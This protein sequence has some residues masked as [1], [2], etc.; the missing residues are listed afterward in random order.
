VTGK[1]LLLFAASAAVAF[2]HCDNLD[3]PVVQAAQRALADNNVNLVLPWVQ[4]EHESAVRDAFARTHQ[5]RKL[6]SEAGQL[7]DQWFFETVVRVHRQG[8]GAPYEGLK[9]AGAGITPGIQAADEAVESGHLA[10]LEKRLTTAVQE[11]LRTKFRRLQE[12]KSHKSAGLKQ[13]R[14]FVAAYVEF[15][16]FAERVH[17]AVERSEHHT[18]EHEH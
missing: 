17:Q 3:G 11:N 14:E 12:A 7:A 8:E 4:P 1:L 5:V 16:H 15:I 10:H 18:S 2:P 6:G 13:G 9:P